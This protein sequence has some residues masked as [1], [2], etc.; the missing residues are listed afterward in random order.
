[1]FKDLLDAMDVQSGGEFDVA[2]PR[3]GQFHDYDEVNQCRVV[4]RTFWKEIMVQAVTEGSQANIFVQN[5]SKALILKYSMFDVFR[6]ARNSPMRWRYGGIVR[7]SCSRSVILA[8][9]PSIRRRFKFVSKRA[10][11]KHLALVIQEKNM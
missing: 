9:A 6:R 11:F 10:G 7:S 4:N 2:K 8:L 5:F 1:M 3:V